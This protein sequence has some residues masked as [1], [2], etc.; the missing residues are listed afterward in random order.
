MGGGYESGHIKC[1]T[2][3]GLSPHGRGIPPGQRGEDQERGPIPAWAGDT[4]SH[5]AWLAGR[6]AYPRMGGGYGIVRSAAVRRRGLSPHGRGI[7]F[8]SSS[9]LGGLG[10]IPAWA[11]DTLGQAPPARGLR[12][13]PRMGGGYAESPWISGEVWGLSPHG[14][15]IRLVLDADAKPDGPIPAWAGDTVQRCRRQCRTGAYPRMGGGYCVAKAEARFYEGLSPH[16]RGIR[17]QA[18]HSAGAQGP[19]PAWAGDTMSLSRRLSSARAYPRMGGGY[20]SE[21]NAGGVSPGLSPHGRGIQVLRGH[22]LTPSGPIPAWAGDTC[23]SAGCWRDIRAYPRM[24]GGYLPVHAARSA[25]W[26]LSPHGRGIP[27]LIRPR[28]SRAGPIPAWAGDTWMSAT[29]G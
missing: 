28:C 14:R 26:G 18:G 16:G 25:A 27:S 8:I 15:G 24:G 29:L 1:S 4:A 6:R 2:W 9:K 3:G 22:T 10:P 13:Y 5:R 7:R 20:R 23:P 19:I 12:A 11:G 21:S 17:S